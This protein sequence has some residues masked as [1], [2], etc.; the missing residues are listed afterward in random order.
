M[1]AEVIDYRV[2]RIVVL[3]KDCGQDVGLYPARHKCG[4]PSSEAPPLP[5]IPEK[6]L[7]AG[8]ITGNSQESKFWNKFLKVT[9]L[10]NAD[11]DSDNGKYEM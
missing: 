9:A 10:N 6:H 3:C 11:Y 7:P 2:S 5:S 1:T 8:K 4:I